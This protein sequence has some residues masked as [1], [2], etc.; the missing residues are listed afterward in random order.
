M[1]QKV[2][3]G[4]QGSAIEDVRPDRKKCLR[5]S[6]SFN[7]IQSRRNRQALAFRYRDKFCVTAAIDQGANLL[8]FAEFRSTLAT[9]ND[10]TANLEARYRR[11]AG[12]HRIHTLPL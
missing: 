5:Q 9:G 11:G 2:F 10:F 7:G 4:F 1:D 8:S 3:A 12:R 6:G